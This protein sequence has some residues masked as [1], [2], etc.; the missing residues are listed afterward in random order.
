MSLRNLI[1]SASAVSSLIL[2]TVD[3]PLYSD[4]L[5]NTAWGSSPIRSIAYNGSV[6]VAGGDNGRL[7]TS[8]DGVTWI[9]QA[10]L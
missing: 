3:V 10:S 5:K 7:A 4:A 6:Y 8:R 2:P 9:F 1:L